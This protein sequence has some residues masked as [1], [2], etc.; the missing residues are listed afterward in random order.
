MISGWRMIRICLGDWPL[1][2]FE[3]KYDI[4]YSQILG[5][6]VVGVLVHDLNDSA[7]RVEG[8]G[9]VKL[10]AKQR[11]HSHLGHSIIAA[12]KCEFEGAKEEILHQL[13]LLE[14]A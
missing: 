5:W 2:E 10:D 12:A 13:G 11:L 14:V 1:A 8:D 6:H 3:V 9:T 7:I 4:S